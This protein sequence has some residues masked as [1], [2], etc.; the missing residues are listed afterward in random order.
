[1]IRIGQWRERLSSWQ[2]TTRGRMI[3][4]VVFVVVGVATLGPLCWSSFEYSA[5][6]DRIAVVLSEAN[7]AQRNPIAMQLI[8]RGTV[9]VDGV[10]IGSVRIQAASDQMF[11]RDGRIGEVGYVSSFV[12]S[13]VAPNWAPINVVERPWL[14]SGIAASLIALAVLA[15]WVGMAIQSIVITLATSLLMAIFWRR[16]SR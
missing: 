8:E 9:T 5:L 10:E 11:A 14:V 1:M 7:I 6:R 2:D 12:A 3:L 15:V 4:T 13:A 16:R